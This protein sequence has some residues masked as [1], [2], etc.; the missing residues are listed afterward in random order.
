MWRSVHLCWPKWITFDSLTQSQTRTH[1]STRRFFVSP[2]FELKI[3]CEMGIA[4]AAKQTHKYFPKIN[5][6]RSKSSPTERIIAFYCPAPWVAYGN[7]SMA[8]FESSNL[9][10]P[11]PTSQNRIFV[12]SG[13]KLT[14][15]RPHRGFWWWLSNDKSKNKNGVHIE[16]RGWKDD[17]HEHTTHTSN[18]LSVLM[19]TPN[20]THTHYAHT[21]LHVVLH[22]R[23]V[24]Y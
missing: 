16:V 21:H 13:V 22:G 24:L 23:H 19:W 5:L 6:I 12:A 15:L 7:T 17:S 11:A 14:I 10:A 1:P 8:T 4:A 2:G 18:S 20:V 9:P 3:N